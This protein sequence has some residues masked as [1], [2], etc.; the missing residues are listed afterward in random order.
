MTVIAFLTHW[1]ACGA[2]TRRLGFVHRHTLPMTSSER[3]RHHHKRAAGARVGNLFALVGLRPQCS[4]PENPRSTSVDQKA[5]SASDVPHRH[6]R[7]VRTTRASP[8]R[9]SYASKH[10]PPTRTG[11]TVANMGNS[12]RSHLRRSRTS[13]NV[14]SGGGGACLRKRWACA[15]ANHPPSQSP[16]TRTQS[17]SLHPR[18]DRQFHRE[19]S[20]WK[21]RHMQR[22]R[23]ALRGRVLLQWPEGLRVYAPQK[24]PP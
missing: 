7:R 10:G 5:P 21:F 14:D 17:M 1:R 4:P 23:G 8:S 22:T 13:A 19:I 18:R 20:P 2:R 15:L 3:S 6:P 11:L 16:A 12:P 9:V 24:K